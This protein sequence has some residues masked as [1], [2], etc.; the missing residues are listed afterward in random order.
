MYPFTGKFYHCAPT[1]AMS[2]CKE[3][4]QKTFPIVPSLLC[5]VGKPA[6]FSEGQV[7]P[8][9]ALEWD[10]VWP[11]KRLRSKSCLVVVLMQTA[12]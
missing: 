10:V 4:Q 5:V 7:A 9:N 6:I 3:A 1:E 8:L 12:I 2:T 11:I